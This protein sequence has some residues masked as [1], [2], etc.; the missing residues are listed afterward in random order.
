MNEQLQLLSILFPLDPLGALASVCAHPVAN[1]PSRFGAAS[2]EPA[3]EEHSTSENT[4]GPDTGSAVS[5]LSIGGTAVQH[6]KHQA[7]VNRQQQQ[8]E[9][10]ASSQQQCASSQSH[11][12]HIGR[13]RSV[14]AATAPQTSAHEAQCK[15]ALAEQKIDACANA[16]GRQGA[17]S[18]KRG[19]ASEAAF[20]AGVNDI[21]K[22]LCPLLEGIAC[23]WTSTYD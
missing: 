17:S 20:D 14:S 18:L 8:S 2:G 21:V 19:A 12:Q 15:D 23:K 16:V 9:H 3:T 5:T 22:A 11:Q 6:H 4:T 7:G 1:L 13:Y 10:H